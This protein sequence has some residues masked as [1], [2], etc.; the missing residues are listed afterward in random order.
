MV[1]LPNFKT[2]HGRLDGKSVGESIIS[3]GIYLKPRGKMSKGVNF[4]FAL[5]NSKMSGRV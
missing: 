1:S 5:K 2:K 3:E 4:N